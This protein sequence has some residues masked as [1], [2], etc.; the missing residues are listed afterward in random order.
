MINHGGLSI[1]GAILAGIISIYVLSKTKKFNFTEHVDV[2]AVVF[3]LC[4]AIGRFG[5]YFNQ[6]AYGAPCNSFIKLFVDKEYRYAQYSNIEYYHPTFLYESMLD[7]IIF[8]ILFFSLFKFKN[9][10]TGT[11]TA[12]YL[13]FY[14]FVRY[15]IEGIRID[16]VLNVGNYP[17]AQI[18]SILIFVIGLISLILINKKR[19]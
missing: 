6:E 2:I 4:Q 13:V 12:L 14:S 9:L 18:F 19:T 15:F 7:I 3:P 11:I 8:L 1:F 16:S 5:N 17:I 10:K